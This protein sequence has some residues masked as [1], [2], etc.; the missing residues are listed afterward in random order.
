MAQEIID[1]ESF[2]KKIEEKILERFN[3]YYKD[4]K[5]MRKFLKNGFKSNDDFK[6]FYE[7]YTQIEWK[8]DYENVKAYINDYE[9]LKRFITYSFK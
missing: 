1:N 5:D 7:L 6:K 8:K 2:E 9:E 4:I 3:R